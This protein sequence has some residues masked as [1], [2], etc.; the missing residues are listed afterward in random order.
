MMAKGDFSDVELEVVQSMMHAPIY[1]YAIPG[2][3]SHMLGGGEFGKVRMFTCDRN[4]QENITPHSHRFDF[5]CLVLSGRVINKKWKA[6]PRGDW[7]AVT[8]LEYLGEP[9]K[10]EMRD[11]GAERYA[12]EATPYTPGQW[13]SMTA[14]EIHSIE[15]SAGSR[16]LF[17]EGPERGANTVVLEPFVNGKRVQTMETKP[18]MFQRELPA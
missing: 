9:G 10:Y 16:V 4:H 3:H 14:E 13:Y 12:M 18:W 11:G 8:A 15:F 5:A 2:L 1:N 17:L 7:F 6:G